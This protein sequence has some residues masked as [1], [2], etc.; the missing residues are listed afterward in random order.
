MSK[1]T[2]AE[3]NANVPAVRPKM[4]LSSEVQQRQIALMNSSDP[5]LHL[6][7][8]DR[9]TAINRGAKI[10]AG[11][12]C[13]HHLRG[14]S[15]DE[16]FSN[17]LAVSLFA[18]NIGWMPNLLAPEAYVVKGKVTYS[19]KVIHAL[20]KNHPDLEGSLNRIIKWRDQK[21]GELTDVR[22]E[23]KFLEMRVIGK[24]RTDEDSR[25]V[26]VRWI[27]GKKA[28]QTTHWDTDGITQL[29]YLGIKVWARTWLPDASMGVYTR[30]EIEGPGYVAE[31]S[32][33]EDFV[34]EIT[35]NSAEDVDPFAEEVVVEEATVDAEEEL[36]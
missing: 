31:N 7:D 2:S 23:N 30:D 3:Q 34:T 10:I 16:A 21:T 27:D 17:A 24:L 26:D 25:H 35:D 28:G 20:V 5:F 32:S 33:T 19:A 15:P 36:T 22:T 6:L 1:T 18:S 29:W 13:G 9:W 4:E 11:G 12:A 14:N 8:D